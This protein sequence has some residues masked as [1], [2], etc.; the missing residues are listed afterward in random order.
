MAK[1]YAKS[2][3]QSKAWKDCRASYISSVNGLC[4]RCLANGKVK[5]GFIVH[6]KEHIK[7]SNIHDPMITLNHENLEYLCLD[8]H[9][10]EH[11]KKH[12]AIREGIT[13]DEE[14]NVIADG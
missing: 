1:E 9:N 14:G 10:K 6:H 4:E 11:F 5:G 8:C 13:I 12:E 2:F 7:P 3:Y